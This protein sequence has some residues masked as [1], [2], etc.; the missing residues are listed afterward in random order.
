M[1]PA[2]QATCYWLTILAITLQRTETYFEF[3][4]L[5]GDDDCDW[6]KVWDSNPR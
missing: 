6:R 3:D 4:D 1:R 2:T 5:E